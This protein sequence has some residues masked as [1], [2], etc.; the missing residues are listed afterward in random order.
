M[1]RKSKLNVISLFSGC[2]GLDYGFEKAGYFI[3]FYNDYDKHSC[4]TLTLNGKKGVCEAPIEDVSTSEARKIAGLDEES[5][6]V[7]IG[8]P[9]C[10]PFSKSA[11]WSKGD[12]LRLEDPRANTLDHYFRFVE[13]LKPEVFLLENVHGL[14]YNGKEEGFRFILDR[15]AGI[16]Q[17]CGT[18][19]QPSWAVLNV[20]NYGVP[21]IRVRFFLVACRS[22][23]KFR[24]P[25]PTHFPAEQLI[26][27]LPSVGGDKYVTAWEAV[28]K[29]P[30]DD[31]Q[32]LSVGGK[33]AELLPSIPE[34]ENYLW[35]TDRK[36]GLPLFGWRTRYWSF[37]LKLSKR[38]PSW[39][40]QAQPGSAIGPF[41]WT[42]RRLS[43]QELA[44]L[45]TFPK[46]FRI[47]SPR[48]EIQRQIGNAVPSLMSEI[49]AR[50][51]SIQF[52]GKKYS[53]GPHLS[54]TRSNNIPEAEVAEDVPLKYHSLIGSHLAHPG[55]GKGRSYQRSK[56]L[57]EALG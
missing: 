16:N 51:I 53:S 55:T 31:E 52:F 5:P 14:N 22:G 46:S 4:E 33:W 18:D 28:G 36:G 20:A 7:L 23:E 41:H 30:F 27:T 25:E 19:Y 57:E 47:N 56:R 29:I 11:Y 37:L 24:F 45:Q 13:E 21:Q 6:D 35:H 50:E 8:G 42:N 10:Q 38:L 43:W 9:P 48:V 54:I 44:A 32:K 12:T 26:S 40:I 15:I 2:G 39:T 3:G 1:I 49:L 34:G 17:K